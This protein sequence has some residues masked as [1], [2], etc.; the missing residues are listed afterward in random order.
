[1]DLNTLTLIVE[2]TRLTKE[3]RHGPENSKKK[4]LKI[5]KTRKEKKAKRQW[6]HAK[7]KVRKKRRL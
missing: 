5:K 2:Q 7:A 6:K 1:M 4:R 3:K